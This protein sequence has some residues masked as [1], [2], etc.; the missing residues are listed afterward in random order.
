MMES[1]VAANDGDLELA[2]SLAHR[3]VERARHDADPAQLV[4]MLGVIAMIEAMHGSDRALPIAEEALALARRHGGTIIRLHPLRAVMGAATKSDPLRVLEAAEEA[5]RIDRTPRQNTSSVARYLVATIHIR[6][7]EIAEGL[8][9]WR[10]VLRSFDHDGLRSDLA[11]SL[12]SLASGLAGVNPLMAVEIAAIVESDA[13]APIAAFASPDLAPL[14]EELATETEAAR[15][16]AATMSYDDAI[17][18]SSARSTGS[19]PNTV[20]IQGRRSRSSVRC[21]CP[22]R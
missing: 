2:A 4:W 15:A 7:G 19:S 8:T 5:A 21:C 12:I 11:L 9:E 6:R 14:V 13:I 3:A 18:S 20:P 22:R 10:E 16:R 1:I 17:A